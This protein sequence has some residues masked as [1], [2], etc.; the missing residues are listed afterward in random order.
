L[1]W[2][3]PHATGYTYGGLSESESLGLAL[4]RPLFEGLAD[5][6]RSTAKTSASGVGCLV[7]RGSILSLR[8]ILLRHGHL[9]STLQLGAILR[10]TVLPAIQFAAEGDQSHV[11]ML[12]SESPSISSIDFLV[13]PPPLPPSHDDPDLQRF[14]ALN[15]VPKRTVG[16]AELLLEAS[17]TDLRHGGDGDLRKAYLLAQKSASDDKKVIEQAFPDSWVA[18]TAPLAL[19]LITD[20]VSEFVVYRQTEGQE[21]LWPLIAE[22]YRLWTVGRVQSLDQLDASDSKASWFPCEA[23]VRIACSDL[24]RLPCNLLANDNFCNLVESDRMIWVSL[25]LNLYSKILTE[26][27]QIGKTAKSNLL[28]LKK[29]LHL[30]MTSDDDSFVETP[31]GTG[32][33]I[34]VRNDLYTDRISQ[35]TKVIPVNVIE[36]DCKA[37]LYQPIAG[38]STQS[39]SSE[40]DIPL[41]VNGKNPLPSRDALSRSPGFLTPCTNFFSSRRILGPCRTNFKGPMCYCVLPSAVT[42]RYT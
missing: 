19:G 1:K 12:T 28:G 14:G 40:K 24:Y 16:P 27:V 25:L 15:T 13:N 33:V 36:L 37:I 29:E 30:D 8:A 9:F 22:Q 17:F 35:L 26:S 11:V 34:S 6:V 18:T 20:L 3:D 23:L 10:E 39:D 38:P 4:W 21:I 41:E 7:Q 2:S 31:Y 32:R 42:S 5:G